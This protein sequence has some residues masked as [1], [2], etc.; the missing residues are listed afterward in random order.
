MGLR[1]GT[2]ASSP[3]VKED[4]MPTNDIC[5]NSDGSISRI[6]PPAGTTTSNTG[7]EKKITAEELVV[8]LQRSKDILA[9]DFPIV[10]LEDGYLTIDIFDENSK[11]NLSVLANEVVDKTPYYAITQRFF[12]NMGFPIDIA[13]T[14]IDWVDIDDSR[15]PY[16]AE[17]SDYYLTLAN[18][19][20]AKNMEMDSIDELLLIKGITPELFY[21]MGGG[22][23]GLEENLV[24]DNKGKRVLDLKLIEEISKGEN[25]ESLK[26]EISNF[27]DLAIDIGKEKSRRLSD[28]FRVNGERADYLSELNKININTASYRVLSALTDNMTDEVVTEIISKRITNPFTSVNDVKDLIDDENVINNIISVKSYL[29]KIVATGNVNRTTVKITGIYYRT[30]K[31]FLYWSE[32]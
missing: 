31:K 5:V 20:S 24:D 15:F 18:P 17:S 4:Y 16:G 9:I 21:G 11:I 28:Y 3:I 32:E 25:L 7:E 14:I 22:T 19:Y 29:F 6:T 30:G 10:P 2:D 1:T 8:L 26:D 23:Y 12:M 13:D 27:S